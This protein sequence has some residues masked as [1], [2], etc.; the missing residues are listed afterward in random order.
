MEAEWSWSTLSLHR[1]HW[2]EVEILVTCTTGGEEE[3]H[4]NKWQNLQC[5]RCVNH[6]YTAPRPCQPVKK[7][8]FLS[9]P[10]H[11]QT[12]KTLPTFNHVELCPCVTDLNEWGKKAFVLPL[13]SSPFLAHIN[14]LC[15]CYYLGGEMLG[16]TKQIILVPFQISASVLQRL[17]AHVF[18]LRP[19][20]TLKYFTYVT[21]S[22]TPTMI[23]LSHKPFP[24]EHYFCPSAPQSSFRHPAALR[25]TSLLCLAYF[26]PRLAAAGPIT[27]DGMES[28]PAWPPLQARHLLQQTSTPLSRVA[29]VYKVPHLIL[30]GLGPELVSNQG[31][32]KPTLWP[33]HPVTLQAHRDITE[34]LLAL[35]CRIGDTYLPHKSLTR[36]SSC[37]WSNYV[38]KTL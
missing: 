30:L 35:T 14:P 36:L 28:S 32:Q 2:V 16:E 27:Y 5:V 1:S 6:F 25:W 34:L 31:L 18:R 11:N 38:M 10:N 7:A 20:K 21:R 17:R 9:R 3:T 26:A 19:M 29:Q 13:R 12:D 33:H 23:H 22:R 4:L 24:K 15:I 37:L 8:Q